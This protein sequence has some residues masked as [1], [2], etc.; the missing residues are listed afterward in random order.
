MSCK[1]T[2][3]KKSLQILSPALLKDHFFIVTVTLIQ[4][5]GHKSKMQVTEDHFAMVPALRAIFVLIIDSLLLKKDLKS[6]EFPYL[7]SRLLP[8]LQ[9]EVQLLF[10]WMKCLRLV[11]QKGDFVLLK[12]SVL[13]GK[14]A[15]VIPSLFR[16]VFTVDPTFSIYA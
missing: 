12:Y 1:S 16:L 10:T 8:E 11:V 2:K 7:Y 5:L 4:Q 3:I 15:K 13:D 6:K 14:P 9:K